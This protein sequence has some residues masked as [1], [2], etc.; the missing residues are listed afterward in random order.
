MNLDL[1]D[2]LRKRFEEGNPVKIGVIG[3]GKFATMFL[4][5]ARITKGFQISA[6]A[7]LDYKRANDA[8][9][10]AGYDSNIRADSL[11]KALQESSIYI[12]ED[13]MEIA[14]AEQ[15]DVIV[16]ATGNPEAGIDH[17][18]AAFNVKSHVVLV[19][20]EADVLCGASLIKRAN[21]AGV[22]CSMAYGDQPSLICELV[23]RIR[24]SGFEIT[25]AGKGTQYLP[26]YHESTPETVWKY[27]GI[28]SQ[29]AVA[30]GLNPKMF[31][32][33]LDGTKSA[34]EMAAVANA[35]GLIVPQNG[36]KF[37]PVGT[38]NLAQ[39]LKPEKEGGII[40]DEGTVEVVS[41]LKR[42]GETISDDLRFGVYVVFKASTEYVSRCFSEYGVCTD[43]GGKYAALWRPVHLIGLELGFSVGKAVLDEQ[44]V[45]STKNF[46]GDVVSVA[47]KDL[48]PGEFLD[49]EGG[50]TV[51]GKLLPA[52]SS[53]SINALPIGLAHKIKII[54]EVKKGEIVSQN[55]VT[56]PTETNALVLR[57]EMEENFNGEKNLD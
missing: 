30:G 48:I 53:I 17:S 39:I 57:K 51:W 38:S 12:T 11:N 22:V 5:Q 37:P 50:R 18:L 42:N 10:T 21:E 20:V 45:G 56:T 55:D 26:I 8:L 29:K 32:S 25:C 27:Y 52:E 40:T 14:G 54:K 43:E 7:D 28:S 13:G 33:F 36:L 34:I 19:T 44:A 16:E 47:K 31:N 3:L 6:V 41:S 4:S 23:E 24:S 15:L 49:G 1:A 9:I 35:T 2:R 46:L